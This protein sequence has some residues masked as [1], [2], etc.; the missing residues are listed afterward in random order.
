M[1]IIPDMDKE[2][3]SRKVYPH[4]GNTADCEAHFCPHCHEYYFGTPTE[5]PNC[6]KKLFPSESQTNMSSKT[7][8]A[9]SINA[10]SI[11]KFFLF[12]E[13]FLQNPGKKIQ[14]FAIVDF[15]VSIAAGIVCAVVLSRD[16]RG[17]FD[18]WKAIQYLITGIAGGYVTAVIVYA[19]GSFVADTAENKEALARVEA[20]LKQMNHR[21]EKASDLIEEQN[22]RENYEK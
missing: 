20:Q 18:F 2:T 12:F 10:I 7:D 15:I 4:E 6:H 8:K 16:R 17:D 21:F 1:R 9:I 22:A 14:W 3:I 13:K 11:N 19:L 5:C